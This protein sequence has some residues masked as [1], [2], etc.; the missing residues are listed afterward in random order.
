MKH[1]FLLTVLILLL[2]AVAWAS[3]RPP[4]PE[5]VTWEYRASYASGMQTDDFNRLGADGWELATV[6]CPEKLQ[7][8][9]QFKRPR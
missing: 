1:G 9:Y 8:I 6:A 7:C 4:A 5:K 3:G 2:A